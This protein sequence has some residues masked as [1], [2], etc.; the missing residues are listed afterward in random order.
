MALD[1]RTVRQCCLTSSIRLA[2]PVR[3]LLIPSRTAVLF[4]RHRVPVAAS[5]AQ[6]R[7]ASSVLKSGL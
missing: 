5:L 4:P 6:S 7:T 1:C 3:K 2:S